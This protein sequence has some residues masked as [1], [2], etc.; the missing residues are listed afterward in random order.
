MTKIKFL[1]SLAIGI[2]LSFQVSA[3]AQK[4]WQHLSY[5]QDSIYGVE[6]NRAYDELIKGEPGVKVIVAVID[7]GTDVQHEDLNSVLWTNK[8]EIAGDGI[9]NDKNGY[10]DDIHGW[11]FLG[12]EGYDVLEETLELTRL[13]ARYSKQFE[14]KDTKKLSRKEKKDYKKFQSIK[15]DF[16]KER[17]EAQEEY[18]SFNAEIHYF[19]RNYTL[20]SSY[21]DNQSFKFNDLTK[22]NT[23]DSI[24][25]NG[26]SMFAMIL[27][28]DTTI[29]ADIVM[30]GMHKK[31]EKIDNYFTE[32]L[33]YNLNP[34]WAPRADKGYNES[35]FEN[36]NYGDNTYLVGGAENG[37]GTHCAG[38]I[39]ADRTNDLGIKGVAANVEIMTVRAVPNGDEHDRDIAA[40]MRYAIDN[41]AR[42][43]SMSYGKAYSYNKKGVDAAIK[44]GV[45]KGV[46]FVHAAGNDG[47]NLDD[48]KNTNFPNV[49]NS[50][51]NAKAWIEVGASSWK[52]GEDLPAVFSNYGKKSVD[53]FAP[54]VDI[55]STVPMSSYDSYSGTS[56]ACPTVAGVAALVMSQ[57]P[58]LS[59]KQVKTILMKTVTNLKDLDVKQPNG[60]RDE[61]EKI[62]KFGSLS[63]TGGVVN[64]YEALKLAKKM[65]N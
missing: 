22:I 52:T 54:G 63:K 56:M 23:Q 8:D 58:N 4:G 60:R 30:R 11:S 7:S 28:A 13:Y 34:E 21:I 36:F 17:S 39:G 32:K 9:D 50:S 48:K 20:I 19:I 62:V 44:Y 42:V 53:L 38:I 6:S 41:G 27:Q 65:S 45:K 1:F 51:S 59:A 37:H 47:K 24:I 26:V 35:D 46:L 31:A 49:K 18:A 3:Q 25:N 16:E 43:I 64:A 14:G 15:A 33:E 57:Y 5:S 2:L 10:I 55:Y 12:G 40:A 61:E 29:S